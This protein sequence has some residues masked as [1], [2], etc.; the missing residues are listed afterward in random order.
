MSNHQ[1]SHPESAG[2]KK[3]TQDQTQAPSSPG[4]APASVTPKDV[5]PDCASARDVVTRPTASPDPEVREEAL[6][7]E[8]IDLTFPASD[9][10][11]IPTPEEVQRHSEGR[12]QPPSAAPTPSPDDS[13]MKKKSSSGGDGKKHA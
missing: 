1:S 9:P 6:L 4:D 2:R 13:R 11:A 5:P 7:D 10:I 12:H 8:A 3:E